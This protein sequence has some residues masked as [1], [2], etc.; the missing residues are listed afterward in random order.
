MDTNN[1]M[2][3]GEKI[4]LE[5]IKKCHKKYDMFHGEI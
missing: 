5:R 4:D 3:D 1:L 2:F